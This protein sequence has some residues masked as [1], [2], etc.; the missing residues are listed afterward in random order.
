VV[1]RKK[2]LSKKYYGIGFFGIAESAN[3][4]YQASSAP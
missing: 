3:A 4:S 2:K 1:K